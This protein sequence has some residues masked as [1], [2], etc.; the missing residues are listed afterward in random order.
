MSHWISVS[1]V[2]ARSILFREAI[3][4]NMDAT[5]LNPADAARRNR[6]PQEMCPWEKVCRSTFLSSG[7]TSTFF[8]SLRF[9]AR[10]PAPLF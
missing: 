4:F 7:A 5:H 10:V 9:P 8:L 6:I 1:A 2:G 3:S